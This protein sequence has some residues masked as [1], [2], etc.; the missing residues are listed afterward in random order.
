MSSI[1]QLTSQVATA[2]SLLRERETDTSADFMSR[3]GADNLRAHVEDL[4]EQLRAAKKAR[5]VEVLEVRLRGRVAEAGTIPLYL[6]AELASKLADSIHATSQKLKS[7]RRVRRISPTI[8]DLLDL[9]LADL[10]PGSTR[11]FISGNIEPDLFGESLLETSLESLF[12]LFDAS[13]EDAL[14]QMVSTVGIRSARGIREFLT[15]LKAAELDVE[16]SWRTGEN[17]VH[18]WRGD[19][20][21]ISRMSR[22]LGAFR[23]VEPSYISVRGSVVALS[24]R[25]KFELDA[26]GKL[27]AGSFPADLLPQVTNLHIGEDV[28][29]TIEQTVIINTVTRVE[30]AN[31]ALVAI[32]A[33]GQHTLGEA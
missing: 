12:E 5:A 28:S 29:A 31:Y 3:L 24:A 8:V 21:A 15:T 10:A 18:F 25:G 23:M 32:A 20:Q 9:R 22:R 13:D 16:F 4:Q 11:L 17:R 14:A 30:K 27:Y 33:T 7:G 1:E 2:R 6:L 26:D 19:Y